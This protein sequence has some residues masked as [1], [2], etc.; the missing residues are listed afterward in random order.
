MAEEQEKYFADDRPL[1][2]DKYL[3]MSDEELNAEIKRLEAEGRKERDRIKRD[4]RKVV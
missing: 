1:N 2:Y 4:D 3:K